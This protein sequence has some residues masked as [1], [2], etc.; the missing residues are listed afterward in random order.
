MNSLLAF[1]KEQKPQHWH[2]SY[3]NSISVL[4]KQ[5]T[6]SYSQYYTSEF[7]NEP[8][9]FTILCLARMTDFFN[10]LI[11]FKVQYVRQGP[12]RKLFMHCC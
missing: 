8:P 12:N 9:T 10:T 1:A 3:W 4:H 7:Q 5:S 6:V 2:Y 11:T